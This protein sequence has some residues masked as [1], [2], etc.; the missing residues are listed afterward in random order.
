MSN[1]FEPE[2]VYP[3][4]G[5]M[6]YTIT[7]NVS[8]EFGCTADATKLITIKE[9]VLYFVPNSFTPDGD[10]FNQEFKP[11]FVSGLDIYDY[12]LMVFNR[13]GELLF[14]SYNVTYGWDGT[15]GGKL[16][17]DG[18][19]V[20]TLDFGETKSDKRIYVKGHVNVLK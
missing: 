12:H 15:Y 19:Y 20:W 18:T 3:G 17:D 4:I 1:E 11:V 8:N 16:V 5:D 6:N 9:D 10:A 14:E 7:L 13:W 2:H